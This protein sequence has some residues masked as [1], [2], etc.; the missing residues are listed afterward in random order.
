M[1]F[2]IFYI[3]IIF[4]LLIKNIQGKSTEIESDNPY[5]PPGFYSYGIPELNLN[6]IEIN[7][8]IKNDQIYQ[9]TDSNF[10]ELIRDGRFYKWF[11]LFYM[12]DCEICITAQKEI[13]IIFNQI[14]N[15]IKYNKIRFAECD[16]NDNFLTYFRFNI[17][18]LGTPYMII[19]DNKKMYE[20]KSNPS[21]P[22]FKNHLKIELL[23]VDKKLLLPFPKNNILKV[24]WNII[25]VTFEKV[26]DEINQNLNNHD[27]NITLTPRALLIGILISLYVILELLNYL[28]KFVFAI[29]LPENIHKGYIINDKT[30]TESTVSDIIAKSKNNLNLNNNG[31]R[32][33]NFE[34]VGEE[35]GDDKKK[36]EEED[37]EEEEVEVEGEEDEGEEG[38]GDGEKEG[39]EGDGEGEGE[40]EGEENGEGEGD[41]DGEE[42]GEGEREGEEDQ[43]VEDQEEEDDEKDEEENKN[44]FVRKSRKKKFIK[45]RN[46][47]KKRKN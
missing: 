44:V 22:N 23:F 4:F 47:K 37:G 21:D 32:D 11:I 31:N 41:G 38:E 39:E 14:K 30:Y 29:V 18:G 35:E 42:E 9:L 24:F 43:E 26:V 34:G 17:T 15:V 13:D 27:I 40:G 12:K 10:D 2:L 19:V 28:L 1:K 3:Y 33:V 46:K 8:E 25:I 20:S 16:V 6:S 7:P 36:G 45:R 5:G